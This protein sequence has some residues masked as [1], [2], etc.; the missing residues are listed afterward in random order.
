MIFLP[1][2]RGSPCTRG[3]DKL[4][5]LGFRVRLWS[6]DDFPGLLEMD[7]REPIVNRVSGFSGYALVNLCHN[8]CLVC[9]EEQGN[10]SMGCWDLYTYQ[11]RSEETTIFGPSSTPSRPLSQGGVSS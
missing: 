6:L 2:C 3:S 7:F 1:Y 10:E 8:C 11:R 9:R 4:W 5:G